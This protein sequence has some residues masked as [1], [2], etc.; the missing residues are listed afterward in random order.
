M[1]FRNINYSMLMFRAYTFITTLG[2]STRCL[3]NRPLVAFYYFQLGTFSLV[4]FI[5][6]GMMGWMYSRPSTGSEG[7]A[8]LGS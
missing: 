2:L 7:H 8:D 5:H 3:S 6:T 1:Y 4:G